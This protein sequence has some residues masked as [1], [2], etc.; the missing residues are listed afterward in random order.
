MSSLKTT[1]TKVPQTPRGMEGLRNSYSA[2]CQ[3]AINA[4]ILAP[5]NWNSI[6]TFGDP[7]TFR[8]NIRDK[9]YYVYNIPISEQSQNDRDDRKAP[10]IQIAIK[11]SGAIHS[12]TVSIF[13][14]N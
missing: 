6:D 14:E 5:N 9:G 2:V 4:N 11:F 8:N 12:S 10:L 13:A 1:N 7:E 3:Q